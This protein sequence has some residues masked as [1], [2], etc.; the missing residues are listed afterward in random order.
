MST[1]AKSKS[2]YLL[3]SAIT[4]P[5]FVDGQERIARQLRYLQH[6]PFDQLQGQYKPCCALRSE[7]TTPAGKL[8]SQ[9]VCTSLLV[10]ACQAGSS[11]GWAS[12]PCSTRAAS[13]RAT[14]SIYVECQ[15]LVADGAKDLLTS[16]CMCK[17]TRC[18]CSQIFSS[19]A[20][21]MAQHWNSK[22]VLRAAR[23]FSCCC[24]RC[25]V[26]GPT[27]GLVCGA[28]VA[29]VAWPFGALVYCCNRPMG[30]RAFSAPVNT[31]ASVKNS[32]PI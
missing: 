20:N 27:F 4:T 13:D 29:V 1:S 8:L 10:F 5:A 32:I 9:E 28:I 6:T 19:T 16:A 25:K 7:A 2:F 17:T 3:L 24:C 22:N 11:S 12:T 23:T 31:W 18:Y 15:R 14:R 26:L 30:D 21:S